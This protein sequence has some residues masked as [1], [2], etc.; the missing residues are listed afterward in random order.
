YLGKILLPLELVPFYPFP[1]DPSLTSAQFA[2][3]ALLVIAAT[4]GA[5]LTVRRHPVW[6]AAWAA[7]IA[8]LFPTLGIVKVGRQAMADRYAYLPSIVALLLVCYSSAS[9]VRRCYSS[10]ARDPWA[11]FVRLQPRRLSLW[12]SPLSAQRRLCKSASGPMA[13]LSGQPCAETTQG[14]SELPSPR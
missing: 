12:V 11:G 1:D 5:L 2:I 10:S 7:Y 6:L 9:R 3:P 8:L 13:S 14:I 4:V